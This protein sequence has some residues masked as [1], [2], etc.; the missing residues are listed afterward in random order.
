VKRGWAA[1]V[2]NAK[3][4]PIVEAATMAI[5]KYQPNVVRILG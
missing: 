4:A 3:A 5:T 2:A 1:Q